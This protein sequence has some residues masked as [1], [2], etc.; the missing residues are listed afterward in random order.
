MNYVYIVKCN[1]G[2]LYTGWTTD[3]DKRIKAHNDGVGAKY[4]KSRLPV[5]LMYFEE[6]SDKS[7][8]LKRECAIKKRKREEKIAL[9][10]K[11]FSKKGLQP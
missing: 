9:F 8:A 10:D 5:S 11:K 4:T 6:F 7:D 2:T 3:I 1:D